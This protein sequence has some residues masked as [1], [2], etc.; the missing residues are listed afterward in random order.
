MMVEL[1]S[2]FFANIPE[3]LE[4]QAMDY[5]DW[6]EARLSMCFWKMQLGGILK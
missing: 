1:E 4:G 5:H 6:N 2:L 3:V